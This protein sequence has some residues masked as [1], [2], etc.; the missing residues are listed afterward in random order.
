MKHLDYKLITKEKGEIF[1]EY[2]VPKNYESTTVSLIYGNDLLHE[3]TYEPNHIDVGYWVTHAFLQHFPNKEIKLLKDYFGYLGMEKT[4]LFYVHIPKC[5]GSSVER[6]GYENGVR[7]SRLHEIKHPYHQP[8]KDFLKRDDLISNKTLFT[9]VRNPY[10]R[11]ISM[12]YCP[13]SQIS[14]KRPNQKITEKDFNRIIAQ[15]I[16]KS[17]TM[18]NFVYHQGKKVIPHV[19]KLENLTQE[20]NNLM[21]E[22]NN[23]I[24]MDKFVNRSEDYYNSQKFTV[25]NLSK[26]NIEWINKKFDNDFYFFNYEK[27]NV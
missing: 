7:W 21:F 18:Y 10:N 4:D 23:K 15:Y 27:I 26:D 3:K 12:V 16:I 2:K 13:Y 24:R 22:Y 19:L 8:S 25:E 17:D 6:C 14:E 9:S 20:F 1:C 5:G 11:L